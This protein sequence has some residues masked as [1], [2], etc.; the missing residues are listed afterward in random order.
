[1]NKSVTN[2]E[3]ESV[4]LKLQRRKSSGPDGSGANSINNV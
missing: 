2:T 4:I 1:M 3:T